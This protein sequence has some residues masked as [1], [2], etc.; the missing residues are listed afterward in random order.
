MNDI[1]WPDH[2]KK[3]KQETDLQSNNRDNG[4][5]WYPS[6][7]WQPIFDGTIVSPTMALPMRVKPS[8]QLTEPIKRTKAIK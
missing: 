2:N 8:I 5:K 7:Y 6:R 3:I 4:S 1:W